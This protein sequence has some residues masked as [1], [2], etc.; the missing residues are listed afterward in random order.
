MRNK[1][2]LIYDIRQI[3]SEC[4]NISFNY[5]IPLHGDAMEEIMFDLTDNVCK[6]VGDK[7]DYLLHELTT[8]ELQEIFTLIN[9]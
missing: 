3:V 5:A 9:N 1:A 7:D 6:L 8:N 2:K 4:G